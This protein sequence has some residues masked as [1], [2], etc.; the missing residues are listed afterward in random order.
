MMPLS[1][2]EPPKPEEQQRTLKPSETRHSDSNHK[3]NG[4]QFWVD[5]GG[6][7]TD[8][9]GLSPKGELVTH[10]VLSED[11]QHYSD[12]ASFAIHTLLA[13]YSESVDEQRIESVRMGTT[14]ATNALLE[15]KGEDTLLVITSGFKDL[16][17]LGYQTRPDIFALHIKKN[18]Q[19]YKECIEVEERLS[20]HGEIVQALDAERVR[21]DLQ[22]HYDLGL[23]CLAIVLMNSYQNN[24]HELAIADL[25]QE[26]GY[27]QISVSFQVSATM[28]IVGRGDTTVVDAYLSPVLRHHVN[29]VV[30][31]LGPE[32]DL[33][34]MQSHGGMTPA[35]N[36]QG[37]DAILSGP[38]GGVVGMVKT[39]QQEGFHQL[40]GFDM[41]GTS[42]DVS[43]FDGG[44]APEEQQPGFENYERCFETEVAGVRIRTPMMQI[45]TVAAGGGSMIRFDQGRFQVGPQSAGANPGPACYGKQGPLTITDC[46]VMLGRLQPQFFPK[47]F[48][49][50][51]NASLNKEAVEKAFDPLVQRIQE[52]TQIPTDAY[53]VAAGFIEVAVDNMAN[54]IKKISIQ[55]GYDVRNYVLCAFGG[56][57]G[58]HAC[59]V[60]EQLDM[61]SI[62]IHQQ[63]SL[64]SAYGIG[65]AEMR[66]MG[67]QTLECPLQQAQLENI[68][69][70]LDELAERHRPTTSQQTESSH[71]NECLRKRLQVKYQGSDTTLLVD[72][73]PE[74][75]TMVEQFNQ[76]HQT[77]FGFTNDALSLTV[78][79]IQVEWIVSEQLSNQQH[80][81]KQDPN[82]Q[83]VNFDNE[84]ETSERWVWHDIKDSLKAQ[85]TLADEFVLS[86][87]K[88]A[89]GHLQ[90]VSTPVYYLENLNTHHRV[91]GPAFIVT[92]N[93]TLIVEP[94][95][96]AKLSELGNIFMV[97]RD[98]VD[99]VT[100]SDVA[101]T[102]TTELRKR[103]YGT[104]PTV[105]PIRLEIYN[106]LFRSVA[107]Q[108]GVV[109][110]NTA[111][112]VN[113]KERLDFSCA[114]F[115]ADGE[116]IANAPHIPVHLGSMSDSVKAIIKKFKAQGFSQGD[117]FILNSPY[118]GGTHLPD[119]TVVRPVF[120]K[121]IIEKSIIEKGIAEKSVTEKEEDQL[122][123]WVAARGHH[124]DVGGITPG[125]M[126]PSSQHIDEEGVLLDGIQCLKGGKLDLEPVAE[127]LRH[128]KYPARNIDQNL[129]DLKAQLAACEKGVQALCVVMQRHGWQEVLSYANHVMDNAEAA[130]RALV[131]SLQ[132]GDF[133]YPMDDGTLLK[134]AVD[135]EPKD[136]SVSIDFSGTSGPHSGNFNAPSS[137]CRAVVLYVFR[138]LIRDNI[139]MNDGIFRALNIK[140]PPQ[141][142]LNPV[143]PAAVVSGNVETAQYLADVIFA[144]LGVMAAAQGTNNNLTFGNERYQYYET[145]CGGTGAGEGFDGASGTHAHMTNSRLTDPEVLEWRYPV[146]LDTFCIRRGSGGQGGYKGGDGVIRRIRFLEPMTVA[147]IS[148]RRLV[149]PFGLKGGLPGLQGKN[150]WIKANGNHVSLNGCDQILVSKN[151]V[152][153][154]Q[155]PG[156][157]GFRSKGFKG[158]E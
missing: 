106:N 155:T 158:T 121:G 17:T 50:A 67:E 150:Q 18:H 114:L 84:V 51:S 124:S 78:E 25:A 12:A 94:G 58:Q 93:T 140:I 112:S 104:S 27:T 20:A 23:R 34:F 16:L 122:C 85:N 132:G 52:H 145:L 83:A 38:A 108:M 37:K 102:N 21:R 98:R 3:A 43:H 26:I 31:Q 22:R 14:V 152:V 142:L 55:R 149:P 4:W 13:D 40:I 61:S 143:Y 146:R 33:T 70:A 110:E 116:L 9:I 73:Q 29:Q 1:V 10:K 113:I 36:F 24:V 65:L 101:Q 100:V 147:M 47:V 79:S 63:A 35:E 41:G 75:S 59:L 82:S 44:N 129:A 72:W 131:P 48:G 64:L 109:L 53:H 105:N 91:V 39:A 62:F 97:R 86:Y 32:V 92:K 54:A 66:E 95:W 154:I 138:C 153:E 157:G 80:R 96:G 137:V 68:S 136:R 115:T 74:L 28:K 144:A 118:H 133:Q 128:A 60:A 30:K 90:P 76:L 130:V 151:D 7:F 135:V 123:F 127:C 69:Q 2:R 6:T 87:Q 89:Q 77:E 71:T 81:K 19:L 15:R 126:P 46:H 88:W 120:A 107:E 156:G 5:R 148:G 45:H 111:V 103:N 8:V 134:V 57:G 49:T 139:P 56:A 119:I 117:G 141:S 125:S 42:T 11:P 99:A